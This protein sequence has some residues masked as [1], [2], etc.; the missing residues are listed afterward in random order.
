MLFV[1]LAVV[2]GFSGFDSATY[3]QPTDSP[4]SSV[5]IGWNTDSTD[6]SCIAYGT[7][8]AMGDTASVAGSVNH[9]HVTLTGLDSNTQYYYN[10]VPSG[11]VR[12]FQTFPA[13]GEVPDS[14]AFVAFG[15]TRSNHGDHTEVM[16]GISASDPA[17]VIHSG[18]LVNDGDK[19]SDWYNFF[20]CEDTVSQYTLLAPSIGNHES[21]YWPY[22]SLYSLPGTE[23]YYSFDY[24]NSHFIALNTCGSLYGA[25]RTWLEND[26]AAASSDPQTDWIFVFFHHPPYSSGSHGSSTSVRTAWSPLFEDYGVDVVFNGHDHS[27]ER[28]IPIDGVT[29]VVTGGGGAPLYGVGSSSWT[30]YSQSLNHYCWI[31]IQDAVMTLQAREPDGTIF[32]SY[33]IDKTVAVETTHSP[34]G[35]PQCYLNPDANPASG[36]V[37]FDYGLP[38][39]TGPAELV[40]HDISGRMVYDM[41]L[42]ATAG[43]FLWDGIDGNGDA[44][45]PGVYFATLIYDNLRTGCTIVFM[46]H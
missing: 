2:I 28:T 42:D 37:S 6:S 31:S 12:T 14:Y 20:L 1:L 26:L 3:I 44:V 40:I 38:E 24:L 45:P 13:Y 41:G 32:D 22:D 11:P 29:Y 39:G 46:E 36:S 15:D 5:T 35:L 33:I 43:N 16:E 4:V 17:F 8:A 27:Y 19:T 7:T 34:A 30:A 18:D 23:D 25:Q 10:V 21:P 9:H